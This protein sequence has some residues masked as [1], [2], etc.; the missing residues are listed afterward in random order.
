MNSRQAAQ[1]LN[2]P[3]LVEPVGAEAGGDGSAVSSEPV[4]ALAGF[5]SADTQAG[6][7]GAMAGF[8]LLAGSGCAVE[9]ANRMYRE[10]VSRSTPSVAAMRRWDQPCAWSESIDCTTVILSRFATTGLLPRQCR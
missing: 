5:E 10:T 3:G 4:G 8:E 7:I 1:S 6:S 9:G 2:R